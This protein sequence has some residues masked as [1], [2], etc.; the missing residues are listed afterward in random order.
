M[1]KNYIALGKEKANTNSARPWGRR[2][3]KRGESTKNKQAN[4]NNSLDA[5]REKTTWYHDSRILDCLLAVPMCVLCTFVANLRLVN[6]SLRCACS[7]LTMTNI[8]VFELPPRENWRRY[9]SYFFPPHRSALLF[10][11]SQR[12][13]CS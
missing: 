9:V 8:N 13:R 5:I 6:V 1:K 2:C 10:I 11:S 7:G 3:S 12:N 4:T